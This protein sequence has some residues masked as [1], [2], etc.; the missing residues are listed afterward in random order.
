MKYALG[1]DIGG[2]NTRVALIDEE[3]HIIN[4]KQFPTDSNDPIQTFKKLMKQ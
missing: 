2:T 1:I 3:Y 4:R